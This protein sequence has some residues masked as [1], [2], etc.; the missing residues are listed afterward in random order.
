MRRS[1]LSHSLEIADSRMIPTENKVQVEVWICMS[2]CLNDVEWN[3]GKR[4]TK[5]ENQGVIRSQNAKS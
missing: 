1:N 4:E 5:K 2:E 3:E